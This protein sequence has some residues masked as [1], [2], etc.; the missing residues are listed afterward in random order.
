MVEDQIRI[1]LL[2]DKD[3]KI[4]KVTNNVKYLIHFKKCLTNAKGG[5]R[6]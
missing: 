5:L 4:I 2:S 1:I 3:K 6:E